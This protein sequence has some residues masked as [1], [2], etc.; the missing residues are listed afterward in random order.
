[1]HVL[2]V[3]IRSEEE[4]RLIEQRERDRAAG[5]IKRGR[6]PKKKPEVVVGQ[7]RE[8]ALPAPGSSSPK[9]TP[10]LIKGSDREADQA[11]RKRQKT[12]SVS[13]SCLVPSACLPSRVA[14]TS[15]PLLYQTSVL[16]SSS[17]SSRQSEISPL[18][19]IDSFISVPSSSSSINVRSSR[20]LKLHST[21]LTLP[22]LFLQHALE[23]QRLC[24]PLDPSSTTPNLLREIQEFHQRRTAEELLRLHDSEP[25]RQTQVSLFPVRSVSTS[26]SVL[27]RDLF[28]LP[29]RSLS[30]SQT[31]HRHCC[32]P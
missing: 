1:M 24:S 25:S 26:D 32:R 23:H 5:L 9:T 16:S 31:H 18:F 12:D 8:P 6:P 20:I 27:C 7:P 3:Q 4:T 10:E 11:P 15:V 28:S 17:T 29:S 14:Y 13:V 30:S 2:A 21:P 22:A 19:N